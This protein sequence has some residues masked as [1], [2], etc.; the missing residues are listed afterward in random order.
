METP[1]LDSMISN[2]VVV[3]CD[4]SQFLIAQLF[5]IVEVF[6]VCSLIGTIKQQT[7]I[8]SLQCFDCNE[9]VIKM[10]DSTNGMLFPIYEIYTFL[11]FHFITCWIR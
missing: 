1:T 10:E 7:L 2:V 6:V 9:I 11:C 8:V 3:E 5:A 4:F